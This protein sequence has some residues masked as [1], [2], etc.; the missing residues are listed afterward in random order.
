MRLLM[1][2]TLGYRF[3]VISL[4]LRN[5]NYIFRPGIASRFAG[6]LPIGLRA[7]E[8]GWRGRLEAGFALRATSMVPTN[9]HRLH[10]HR[11]GAVSR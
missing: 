9:R 3:V 5:R 8:L 11:D 2:V 7:R 4:R 10:L 1:A 6:D